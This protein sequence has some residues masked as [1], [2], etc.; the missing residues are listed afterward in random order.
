LIKQEQARGMANIGDIRHIEQRTIAK[1]QG[2][3]GR[4]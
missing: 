4:E 1:N 3:F 2:G